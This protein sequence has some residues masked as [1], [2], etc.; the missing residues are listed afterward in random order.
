[1]SIRSPVHLTVNKTLIKTVHHEGVTN[2][3][4]N[5]LENN[6]NNTNGSDSDMNST[7]LDK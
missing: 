1:M 7:L 3:W 2:K 6:H 5:K 4:Q